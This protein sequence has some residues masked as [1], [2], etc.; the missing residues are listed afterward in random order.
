MP[1]LRLALAQMNPTVGDISGNSGMIVDWCHRARDAGADIV[2]FPEMSL[3][4]YPI[5]DLAL[6]PS[7]QDASRAA[8]E[9]LTRSLGGQGLGNLAVVV[10]LLDRSEPRQRTPGR[11]RNDPLNAAWVLH[12]GEV[13]GRYAKHHLPNYGVFDEY[14]YFVPGDSSCVFRTGGADVSLAICEDLWQE[15]GPVSRVRENKSGLLLVLNGSPY[16]HAK[17]DIRLDL[18]RQRAAEADCP[19]AYVNMVGGQDELVFDGDSMIVG[20]DGQ[21]LARAPQFAEYLLVADVEVAPATA[22]TRLADSGE[23]IV[24]TAA[25]RPGTL[26]PLA[27][28]PVAPQLSGDAQVYAALVMGLRDYVRKNGFESVVLGLSG[29]IDSALTAAIACD[30]L[31]ESCV[32]GVGL[33]SRYSSQHSQDD[34]AD[35]ATRTGLTYRQIPIEPI[36]TQ[37]HQALP[38]AGL[39]AENIQ[40][41]IRGVILMGISNSEGHLV[42]ATGNK[43]EIS[44]GYTTIY[45]DAVGGFAPIKDVPKSA[46]WRLAKWRNAE[47]VRLGLTPP[48]PESSIAKAPSAEL[49]PDQ[50]DT[51][52][53]P[54][55]ALLDD[56]LDDYVEHDRSAAGLV[57]DGFAPDLVSRVLG[58][59]DAAEYKR[60]QYPPGTKIS[61]RAFGRDRRLPIT[62]RWREHPALDP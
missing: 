47:A 34:A 4:G 56:V 62:N 18:C 61:L 11:P 26:A 40:A 24:L 49:R 48:I 16:E 33:P 55:Y 42:L 1:V 25:P 60:R 59:T 50:F 8:A 21:V 36:V 45:G 15:G 12:D 54:D 9:D 10:G 44:V 46:V 28:A 2:A 58:L 38:L 22:D 3:T 35:L 13:R 5:E 57:A 14:R 6:R 52:T 23:V 53:L 27:A 32:H 29:G 37:I 17:E 7:F 30:A 31:G 19:L 20:A 39:A 43:T 51:D 41:R